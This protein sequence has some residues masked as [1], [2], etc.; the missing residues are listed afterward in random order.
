MKAGRL[1]TDRQYPR[2]R[3]QRGFTLI[4]IMVVIVIMGILAALIVPRLLDRPDQARAVAARQD[5][6]ALMQALKLYRLD[7]G[8]YP[9]TEQGL[10]A[11]VERPASGSGASSAWRAYLDRLPNDPWGHP[12]QYLN[13]GTRGEIDVFSLGADGKPDGDGGNADIGSWQL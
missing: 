11:L 7:T 5:I 12:Y 8:S 13:P 6:S 9:S 1:T 3:R 4:E 10:R 2:G